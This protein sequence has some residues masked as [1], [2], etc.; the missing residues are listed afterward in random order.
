MDF[1]NAE[2]SYYDTITSHT[3]QLK[4]SL[5]EEMKA[6]IKEDDESV[7]YKSN[8]YFYIT[9]Y[10]VGGQYPIH[11]RKKGNLDA[12]EEIMFDVNKMAEGHEYYAL[13]GPSVSEDN[14][15]AAFAVDT[16][17]RR[18]YT[19]QFKNLETGKIYPDKIENTTGGATWANDNK[20]VFYTKQDPITL[21]SDKI[22]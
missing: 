8:G 1:L 11:A 4:E 19:L 10:E 21:R 13:R 22:F 18:K 14:K 16:V 3:K 9:R 15:I 17:S 7:P 6:R 2:N 12:E 20:T 5:F